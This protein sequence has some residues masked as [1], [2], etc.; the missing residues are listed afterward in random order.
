MLAVAGSVLLISTTAFVA[1]EVVSIRSNAQQ[2]LKGL[3]SM[4]GANISASM[5]FTDSA[6]ARD[7]LSGFESIPHIIA[8]FMHRQN[9]TIFSHYTTDHHHS[10]DDNHDIHQH[11]TALTLE[12]TSSI[13]RL[14]Y[15]PHVFMPIYVES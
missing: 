7:L 3:A 13:F 10:T 2:Q 14:T 6:T 12:K 4:L 9:S 5:V 15:G 8:A 11:A 1:S